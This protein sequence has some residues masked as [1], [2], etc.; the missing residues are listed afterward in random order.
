MSC[1][2]YSCATVWWNIREDA[3][4]IA[5]RW[6]RRVKLR[7][8]RAGKDAP[9]RRDLILALLSQMPI[10]FKLALERLILLKLLLTVIHELGI[11]D[12]TWKGDICGTHS[13][14]SGVIG[15]DAGVGLR[16]FLLS[17]AVT[18]GDFGGTVYLALGDV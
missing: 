4:A 10:L 12:V 6:H 7:V 17:R 8:F 1:T 2:C 13:E 9:Y 14:E 5:A 11:A 3:Q 15:E 18:L 16:V